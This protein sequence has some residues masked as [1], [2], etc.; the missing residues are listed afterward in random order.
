MSIKLAVRVLC[1]R[2]SAKSPSRGTHAT[3]DITTLNASCHSRNLGC[4]C[5]THKH[6]HTVAPNNFNPATLPII[7]GFWPQLRSLL[8]SSRDWS[9]LNQNPGTVGGNWRPTAPIQISIY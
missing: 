8:G 5:E 2:S 3:C 6:V 9:M 1:R 4:V 7:V